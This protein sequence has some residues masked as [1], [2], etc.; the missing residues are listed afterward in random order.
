MVTMIIGILLILLILWGIGIQRKLAV[1]EEN[2]NSAMK[3]IGIQISSCFD[4]LTAL[5]RLTGEY[6]SHETQPL[7]EI[8]KS[9]RSPITAQSTPSDVLK[10]ERILSEVLERISIVT[11][12]YPEL[13]TGENYTR[14]LNAVDGYEKMVHTSRLIYNDSVTRLNHELHMFPTSLLGRLFG[15]RL[16]EYLASAEDTSDLLSMN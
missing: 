3:Q 15:F 13:K 2:I 4:A 8:V 1:M 16:K 7:F 10:Q 9:R 6:A 11:A 12:Q 14:C 5:L